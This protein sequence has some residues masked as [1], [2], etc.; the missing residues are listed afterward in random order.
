LSCIGTFA[1]NHPHRLTWLDQVAPAIE[2]IL[3]GN[4]S[5]LIWAAAAPGTAAW[6]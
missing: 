5:A 3:G 4:L 6:Q 2:Y 1:A